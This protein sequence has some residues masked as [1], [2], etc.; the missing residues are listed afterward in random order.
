MVDGLRGFH[1]HPGQ[2]RKV[3]SV[4]LVASLAA[5]AKNVQGVLSFQHLLAKIRDHVAHR[6]LDVAAHDVVVAQRAPLADADAVER[7][8]D[9]VRKVVLLLGAPG[10][11]LRGQL[12]KAIRGSGRRALELGA[13]RSGEDVSR[14]EDHAARDHGDPLDAAA[15]L[16]GDRG[17]KRGGADASVLGQQDVGE[18]VVVRDSAN[19]RSSGTN[20]SSWMKGSVQRTRAPLNAASLRS[21]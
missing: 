18:L 19:A 4:G 5:V 2:E 17:V 11:K 13:L 9:R 10:K 16:S 12:L 1:R 7:T 20:D 15:A 21:L 6:E 8:H 14:L 3:A